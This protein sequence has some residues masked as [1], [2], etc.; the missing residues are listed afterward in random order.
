MS[1]M[2]PQACPKAREG[3]AGVDM[4]TMRTAGG[5]AILKGWTDT[6][7]PCRKSKHF[8]GKRCSICVGRKSVCGWQ[9][10][11]AKGR[12]GLVSAKSGLPNSRA[13]RE[14][15]IS[16]TLSRTSAA[17]DCLRCLRPAV[18]DRTGATG[19]DWRASTGHIRGQSR[20]LLVGRCRRGQNARPRRTQPIR[21]TAASRSE[22]P[23]NQPRS[24][25]D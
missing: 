12:K 23:N 20:G 13:P 15:D 1:P 25:R 24:T 14:N 3:Q 6:G 17:W 4:T 16:E 19:T 7:M 5:Y 9:F 11:A 18:T 10:M 2:G 8:D 21:A 22:T